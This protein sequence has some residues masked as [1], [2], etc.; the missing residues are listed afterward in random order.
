MNVYINASEDLELTYV[1]GILTKATT[2]IEAQ[3]LV[4][5]DGYKH[6]ITLQEEKLPKI[7]FKL[8]TK[9]G[10]KQIHP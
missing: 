4:L 5:W 9:N 8:K 7:L 2:K 6:Y 10:D 1:D 3:D